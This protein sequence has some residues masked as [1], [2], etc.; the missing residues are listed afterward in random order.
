MQTEELIAR[1][2]TRHGT[3]LRLKGHYAKGE[4]H[5]AYAVEDALGTPLVLKWQHQ[6]EMLSHLERARAV[7]DRLITFDVPVPRPRYL[8]IGTF[9]EGTTY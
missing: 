3:E 6:P 7:T 9:P 5:G 1:L 8:L 4:N 2:N